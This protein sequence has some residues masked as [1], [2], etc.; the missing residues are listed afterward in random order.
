MVK[1]TFNRWLGQRSIDGKD[2]RA[3]TGFIFCPYVCMLTEKIVKLMKPT[4]QFA[5]LHVLILRCHIA[6]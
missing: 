2:N 5:L 4:L 6:Y 3:H 1:T